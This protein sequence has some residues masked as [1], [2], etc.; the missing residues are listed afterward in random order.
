MLFTEGVNE[1][2]RSNSTILF[3]G[4]DR[5]NRAVKKLI[6]M[7]PGGTWSRPSALVRKLNRLVLP[8]DGSFSHSSS[9][10]PNDSRT[11]PSTMIETGPARERPEMKRSFCDERVPPGRGTLNSGTA[12]RGTRPVNKGSDVWV[13][14]SDTSE[15]KP[16]GLPSSVPM[17]ARNTQC[18]NV[19]TDRREALPVGRPFSERKYVRHSS[20][21]LS[22][23]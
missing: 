7:S 14:A 1:K 23:A 9:V 19:W 11:L 4:N 3:T 20:L 18:A 15:G 17:S 5:R 21:P 2:Y 8:G 6:T 12:T 13:S 16:S 22:T 10:G